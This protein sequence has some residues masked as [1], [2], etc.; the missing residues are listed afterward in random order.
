MSQRRARIVISFKVDIQSY[1]LVYCEGIR[2]W[3]IYKT[4]TNNKYMIA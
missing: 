4:Q 2:G 3:S 1:K